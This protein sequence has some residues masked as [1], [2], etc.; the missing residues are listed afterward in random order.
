MDFYRKDGCTDHKVRRLMIQII[1]LQIVQDDRIAA[2]KDLEK[3][4]QIPNAVV[5]D[6]Y[7]FA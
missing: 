4:G 5:Q 1:I 7:D 2:A 6:E 3:F